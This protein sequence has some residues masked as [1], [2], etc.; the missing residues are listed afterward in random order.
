MGMTIM[1]G[2]EEMRMDEDVPPYQIYTVELRMDD[3]QHASYMKIHENYAGAL[4]KKAPNKKDVR[5]LSI[6][7]RSLCQAVLDSN[8]QKFEDRSLGKEPGNP[9]W[10]GTADDHGAE[11][12]CQKTLPANA[13]PYRDALGMAVYNSSLSVKLQYLA[14]LLKFLCL[15]SAQ[16]V[17]VF[18]DWPACQWDV[19]MFADTLGIEVISIRG[20]HNSAEREAACKRFNDSKDSLQVLVASDRTSATSLNLQFACCRVVFMESNMNANT[21]L[22]GIGRV[23]RI[24]QRAPICVWILIVDGTYD[25]CL[26][27]RQAR[28]FV[29]QLADNLQLSPEVEEEVAQEINEDLRAELRQ[30]HIKQTAESLYQELF[31]QRSARHDK[32]WAHFQDLDAKNKLPEEKVFLK[33]LGLAV[34]RKTKDLHGKWLPWSLAPKHPRLR[35]PAGSLGHSVPA[36]SQGRLTIR[37]NAD[38]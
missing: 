3:R 23:F 16:R 2:D 13:P 29:S 28:K 14:G 6:S 22:Q 11:F 18:C 36:G 35:L 7:H 15:D 30:Q 19:E 25:Q 5:M 20:T 37:C 32:R 8:L 12:Y 33:S 24:G 26:Q 31:G 1:I 9:A 34:V 17:L 21:L 38:A 27:A 10:A 4:Y